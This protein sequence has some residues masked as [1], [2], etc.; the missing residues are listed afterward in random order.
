MD[1]LLEEWL[2]YKLMD[3]FATDP[4]FEAVYP[5]PAQLQPSLYQDN[6]GGHD[7]A[8]NFDLL[9]ATRGLRQAPQVVVEFKNQEDIDRKH[10]YQLNSFM[11]AISVPGILVYGPA[12]RR[13]S[14]HLEERRLK[15]FGC[16]ALPKRMFVWRMSEH[17]WDQDVKNLAES[18]KTTV[19]GARN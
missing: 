7:G 2:G 18:I 4:V 6:G 16:V 17:D 3:C 9:I 10:I 14:G 15:N 1:K 12:S 5:V 11:D 13:G 8:C 19:L